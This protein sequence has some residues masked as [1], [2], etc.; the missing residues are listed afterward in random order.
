[1]S[2]IGLQV[3]IS[4]GKM[5]P[6]SITASTSDK[7]CDEFSF[8]SSRSASKL[9]FSTCAKLEQ[10]RLKKG[11]QMNRLA[12]CKKLIQVEAVV[13]HLSSRSRAAD[14]QSHGGG[15]RSH[16]VDRP[17]KTHSPGSC[18]IRALGH[19]RLPI[20]LIPLVIFWLLISDNTIFY[21]NFFFDRWL[22]GM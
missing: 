22:Q 20:P 11:L 2:R 17:S 7:E 19:W 3:W 6:Y 21:E 18:P 12:F 16:S 15:W 10:Q 1:M 9:M 5:A 14:R 8:R 4:K 13:L